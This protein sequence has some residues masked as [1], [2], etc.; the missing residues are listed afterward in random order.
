MSS[1]DAITKVMLTT[2]CIDERTDLP[3]LE[4]CER[5]NNT[6]YH[7][8]LK[9]FFG[10]AKT[11]SENSS[12]DTTVQVEEGKRLLILNYSNFALVIKTQCP[13][14]RKASIQINHMDSVDIGQN[15]SKFS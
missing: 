8:D 13:I 1:I 2:F 3:A 12:D 10:T 6:N 15:F 11:K 14:H 4:I 7:S 5:S 9:E